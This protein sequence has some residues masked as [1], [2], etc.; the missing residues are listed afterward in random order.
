MHLNLTMF[1]Y[2]FAERDVGAADQKTA[3]PKV[4]VSVG[5]VIISSHEQ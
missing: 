5:P 4:V 3:E 1:V 2:L